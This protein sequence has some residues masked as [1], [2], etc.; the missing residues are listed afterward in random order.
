[1]N[2]DG[3]GSPERLTTATAPGQDADPAYSPSGV[4][5]AFRRRSDAGDFDLYAMAAEAAGSIP[6]S[7]V[8]PS[9]RTRPS[10]RLQTTSRSRATVPMLPAQSVSQSP[11][12]GSPPRPRPAPPRSCTKAPSATRV[13]PLGPAA[14]P[15]VV[16]LPSVEPNSDRTD[17]RSDANLSACVIGRPRR[18][19]QV[20]TGGQ[21]W[22]SRARRVRCS[23][24]AAIGT[25]P[26]A[27]HHRQDQRGVPVGQDR[28]L[29]E[30]RR[31]H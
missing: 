15:Q 23:W 16:V 31:R 10:R 4:V 25:G 6:S 7:C 12:S 28:R 13:L 21:I 17:R 22:C 18:S 24:T 29:S 3:T 5:I 27:P 20:L 1:M 2:A 14:E 9:T 8:P 19:A 11:A 30:A 26:R